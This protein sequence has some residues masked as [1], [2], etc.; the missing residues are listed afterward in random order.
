MVKRQY[1]SVLYSSL[2]S[3]ETELA[4]TGDAY[5][6]LINKELTDEEQCLSMN[7][8]LLDGIATVANG[9]DVEPGVDRGVRN[10]EMQDLL[11]YSRIFAR[12]K[13]HQKIEIVALHM[14]QGITGMC[15]DGANDAGALRMAHVGLALAG[16]S[17]EAT[18]VSSFSTSRTSLSAIVDMTRIGRAAMITAIQ[19]YKNL[20]MYGSVMVIVGLLQ[21]Y[22]GVILAEIWWLAMDLLINAGMTFA[23]MYA[24]PR[25]KLAPSRPTSKLLGTEVVTSIFNLTILCTVIL[26]LSIIL[27]FQQSWFV[28][29]EFDANIVDP[30][31]WY[32]KGD[33][34]EAAVLGQLTWIMMFTSGAVYNF[35]FDYRRKWIRNWAAAALAVAGLVLG[36]VQCVVGPSWLSCLFRYNCGDKATLERMMARGEVSNIPSN[37]PIGCGCNEQIVADLWGTSTCTTDEFAAGCGCDAE[38]VDCTNVQF[39]QTYHHNVI[40]MYFRWVIFSLGLIYIALAF[41][42]EGFWYVGCGRRWLRRWKAKSKEPRDKLLYGKVLTKD[43]VEKLRERREHDDCEEGGGGQAQGHKERNSNYE[44]EVGDSRNQGE[45]EIAL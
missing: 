18:M 44:E 41:I 14:H 39:Q 19:C 26:L 2:E 7:R 25:R 45:F 17:T 4:V 9:G 43:E 32:F 15:G 37:A 6:I 42:I 22:F 29:R 33:N 20:M 38:Y 40:P 21:Y 35:G 31:A 3:G 10:S 5:D 1:L 34:Y 13:P 8:Y 36:L 30:G 23:I 27:L 24:Q 16:G 12:V 11:R 28:C